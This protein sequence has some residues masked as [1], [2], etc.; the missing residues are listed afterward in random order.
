M[1]CW[2]GDPRSGNRQSAAARRHAPRRSGRNRCERHLLNRTVQGHRAGEDSRSG[3]EPPEAAVGR[4]SPQT[5]ISICHASHQRKYFV[6]ARMPAR[7]APAPARPVRRLKGAVA[8]VLLDNPCHVKATVWA[9]ILFVKVELLLALS[10][11]LTPVLSHPRLK[12]LG[13]CIGPPDRAR[14]AN[15]I[16]GAAWAGCRINS[17][18]TSSLLR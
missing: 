10:A 18:R 11:Q 9:F 15:D 16:P 6:C 13:G 8:S 14:K 3:Q 7:Y 12:L 4:N 5:Q 17:R 1:A 2:Q